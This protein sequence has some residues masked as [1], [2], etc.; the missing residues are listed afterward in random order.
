MIRVKP[1]LLVSDIEMAEEDGYTLI[2]KVR[3][4]EKVGERRIPAV[5]LTANAKPSDRRGGL[6]MHIPKPVEPYSPSQTLRIGGADNAEE[7]KEGI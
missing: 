3:T 6:Q 7:L 4:S 2:H 5:A 1:G